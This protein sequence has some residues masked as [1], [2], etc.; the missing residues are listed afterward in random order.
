MNTLY[1]AITAAAVGACLLMLAGC[2]DNTAPDS[3]DAQ[4]A[5]QDIS[6]MHAQLLK[7]YNAKD[8][9]GVA[10]LYTDDSILMPPNAATVKSK[11][12]VGDF[13]RQTLVPPMNSML[14]N[15]SE[16]EVSGDYAFSTGYYTVLR[17]DGTTLDRGKFMEVLQHQNDGWRIF[18]DIY[19]SDMAGPTMD[20]GAM[21]PATPAPAAATH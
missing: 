1:R 12:A 17:A 6:D 15:V 16:T 10:A 13:M 20:T 21:A 8:A 7:A 14:L 2:P 5:K 4:A 11:I 18:R 19:N 9:A 3:R